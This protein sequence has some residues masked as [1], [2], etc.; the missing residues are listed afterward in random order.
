MNADEIQSTLHQLAAIPPGEAPFVSL[1]LDMRTDAS[2]TRPAMTFLKA[3]LVRRARLFGPRGSAL[4]SFQED[5][6]RIESY[7]AEELDVAFQGVALFT[8]HARGFFQ[9]VPLPLPPEN[10]LTVAQ[11]PRLYQLARML[12]NYETYCVVVLSRTRARV[13]TVVMGKIAEAADLTQTHYQ[14]SKTLKGGWSQPTYQRGIELNIR[15]FAEEVVAALKSVC[16]QQQ[17]AHLV[18]A[19]ETL[20]LAELERRLPRQVSEMVLTTARFDADVPEHRL[21]AE[22]LPVI[23]TAERQEEEDTV[24]EL[25]SAAAE[26]ELATMGVEST[27]VALEQGQV[28]KLV[29]SNAFA[30]RGWRCQSCLSYG[31]GGL[32]TQC[33]YCTGAIME[34]D[35]HESMVG[36]A[37]RSGATIEF[38]QDVPRLDELGGVGAFLRYPLT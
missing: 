29:L 5:C 26:G 2:G 35:L 17:P 12:D 9:A 8:C 19:G 34:A 16:E 36:A 21:L 15:R 28:D 30:A 31:V 24:Q 23:E 1:Y 25:E 20:A 3:A 13:F 32:P 33:P 10:R 4:E 38:V 11:A 22:I 6:A 37:E 27:L 14:V 7:L 18:L